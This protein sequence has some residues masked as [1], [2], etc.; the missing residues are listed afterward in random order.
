V[1][2]KLGLTSF[3]GPIAHIGYFRRELIERRRWL[4]EEDF[5]DLVGLC[6]FLPGPTS[7]Q[8]G[9]ALGLKRAGAWGGVAAWTAFTMPSALLLLLFGYVSNDL[10]GPIGAA[11]I[12]GLK[13][14]A[15]PIV[16]QAVIAM[17]RTLT[18]DARRVA[19]ALTVATLV[20]LGSGASIQIEGILIGA[21]AGLLFCP[22]AASPPRAT[23]GWGPSRRAGMLC[24]VLF[25]VLLALALP[26]A[27]AT[28]NRLV[29]LAANFYRAGALVFGGGHVVLP[30]IRASMVPHWIDDAT[31]L[32]GYGAAQ[33]VPGPLFTFAAFVG[34]KVFGIAGAAV[35]LLSIFVPG[36]LLVAGV[37][38]LHR[39][40]RTS[41]AAQRAL[42][43]VNAAVVG[44]LGA[45]LYAPLWTT[46]VRS[47]ADTMIVLIA[48]LLLIRWNIA[49]LLIVAFTVSASVALAIA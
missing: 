7:S 3:G 24:L 19:I 43:G 37:L 26:L 1:F 5:A 2:L 38:Q 35:A 17:A 39:A 27:S 23:A 4:S 11:M 29:A 45:A 34:A 33:A 10:A 22:T 8:T 31:F 6:Q 41:V 20:L 12:H 16:A 13:L 49:P 9:F 18:P 44:I 48:L 14:V 32:A 40:L 30:L 36:L 28:A 25:A 47:T 15:I 42:A 21:V 46:G